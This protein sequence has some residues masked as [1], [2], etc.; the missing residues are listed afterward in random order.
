MMLSDLKG[1]PLY[2][3]ENQKLFDLTTSRLK[4][5]M[6]QGPKVPPSPCPPF[7]SPCCNYHKIGS[8]LSGFPSSFHIHIAKAEMFLWRVLPVHPW[9]T[10]TRENSDLPLT[11]WGK[12]I[13][14]N[15]RLAHF[16]FPGRSCH[17]LGDL[18]A[19]RSVWWSSAQVCAVHIS[20]RRERRGGGK[21]VGLRTP[22]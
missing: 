5:I 21:D 18:A 12:V 11:R 10:W 1:L 8:F 22:C 4:E 14:K 6:K 7:F 9:T 2:S 3:S 17:V 16:Y 19:M 13:I 20:W 15:V